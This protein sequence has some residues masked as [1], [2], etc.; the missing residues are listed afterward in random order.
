[1]A[2]S[3]IERLPYGIGRWTPGWYAVIGLSLAVMALGVFAYSRQLI[4]GEVVTGLRNI[5]TMRGATWGLYVA[6]IVYFIGVSFAGITIAAVIRL[7]NLE[8]LRPISRMAE[9]LTVIALILGGLSV[10]V[11]VGRPLRALIYLPL[12]GRPMSP[13][14]GTFTLVISGY[15]FASL[16]Y[17]YLA[18]RRD[19]AICA[20]RSEGTLRKFYRLWAAGYR[21][22]PAEQVRHQR[23]TFWLAIAILPLL[24]TAHSTLGFVFG[25]QVGR[26][27]WFSAL[28]APGFV[29]LAGVSGLGHIIVIAAI[30]RRVL[31][32][33][34]QLNMNVFKWL[35]N[36]LMVLT[37]A[38]LYLM[39]VEWLTTT[40]TGHHH[41]R[42]LL[43]SLL[44]GGYAWLFW[45]SV[46]S[47]IIPF[48]LL[49]PQF[50]TGHYRLWAIV[51]SGLLVNLAAIGKR[52]LVV[53]PSQTHGT[54]LP[55][56]VGSYTP[57][58]VEYS[59][60]LGLLALGALL[61]ILFMKVFPIM[62]V[63]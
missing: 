16:V 12:Y 59:V 50:V 40:Y 37:I 55:Y 15:L 43:A 32:V 5:G 61:Y 52:V 49:F 48:L 25:L 62:E 63:T 18:G 35:A 54:L 30:M 36:L 22:T 58:W 42:I 20:E 9:L 2:T 8:H 6:F 19:A 3:A 24:V 4:E 10:V 13:F 45:L 33:K 47:L 39:V 17:L 53:V 38:Y 26:P 14:F 23:A 46:G 34:D 56:I 21:D 29:I 28:Q 57:T 31:G 44:T 27:G 11:D 51:L 1:M 41:E 60:I 7:L